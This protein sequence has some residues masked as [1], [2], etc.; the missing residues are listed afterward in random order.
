MARDLKTLSGNIVSMLKTWRE[1][2]VRIVIE[3]VV[4][5][6]DERERRERRDDRNLCEADREHGLTLFIVDKGFAPIALRVKQR[7]EIAVI[8]ARA[9]RFTQRRL[10]VKGD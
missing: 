4:V 7:S 5:G 3:H 10:A 8:D 1:L 9:G 2:V 6:D